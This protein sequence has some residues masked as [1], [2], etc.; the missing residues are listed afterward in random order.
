M[1]PV[2]ADNFSFFRLMNRLWRS[3]RLDKTLYEEVE[4]DPSSIKEAWI[5][6]ILSG[7]ASA[8]VDPFGLFWFILAS[9][10]SWF[11][12]AAVVYGVGVKIF[13]EPATKSSFRELLRVLGFASAP[14]LFRI[15]SFVPGM[16]IFLYFVTSI[17]ILLAMIIAIRQSL[18]YSS[19][20]KAVLICITAWLL[21]L[22]LAWAISFIMLLAL[23]PTAFQN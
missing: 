20:G 5:I 4:H 6:V 17:W 3:I 12:W 1:M 2:S 15:F 14:G 10:M 16:A 11:L 23:R 19:T 13:P 8:S 18:D 21:Q 22:I 9:V 7:A